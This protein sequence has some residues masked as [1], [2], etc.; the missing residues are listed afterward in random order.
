MSFDRGHAEVMTTRTH[1]D[2][3]P[4][5]GQPTNENSTYEE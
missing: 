1:K 2:I 3:R 5:I 4:Y